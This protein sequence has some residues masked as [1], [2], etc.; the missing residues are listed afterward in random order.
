MWYIGGIGTRIG[1]KGIIKGIQNE[2]FSNSQLLISR[3]GGRNHN[4]GLLILRNRPTSTADL[5]LVAEVVDERDP[6]RPAFGVEVAR[7]RFL[8]V[9]IPVPWG[10]LEELEPQ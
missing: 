2:S 1:I 6:M 5:L 10:I 7:I 9:A 3:M 4:S 8:R